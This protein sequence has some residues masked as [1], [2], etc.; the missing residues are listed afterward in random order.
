MK[1]RLKMSGFGEYEKELIVDWQQ[2]LMEFPHYAK[3]DDRYWGWALYD[4]DKTGKAE[5]FLI[6]SEHLPTAIPSNQ[7]G[8]QFP[9]TDFELMFNINPKP[10][11]PNCECGAHHTA[12]PNHHL[13][14][15]PLWTK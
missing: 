3:Y 6:F 1:L 13:S 4:P 12:F 8:Q 5:Y 7:Y 9:I 14:F 15:C 10:P 11:L 2:E